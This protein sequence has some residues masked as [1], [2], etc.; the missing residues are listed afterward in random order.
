MAPFGASRAGLMS[1]A[2]DDIPDSVVERPDDDSQTTDDRLTGIR[3]E[4]DDEW[5]E[6]DVEISQNTSDLSGLFVYRISDGE[7]IGQSSISD[8]TAGDIYTIDLDSNIQPSD[9][10]DDTRYNILG[11]AGGSEYQR[12][13]LNLSSFPGYESDDGR[14]RMV[15]GAL[16]ET[17][18]NPNPNLFKRIG[19]L[20]G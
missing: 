10:T 11:D 18:D 3:I 17:G 13:F 5:P 20:S 19:N 2:E 4:S 7:L 9:G 1:V 8:V 12:G 15:N 6:I 16:G 14:L